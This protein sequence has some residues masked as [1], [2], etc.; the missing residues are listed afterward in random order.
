[1]IPQWKSQG[2]PGRCRPRPNLQETCHT[3]WRSF[4]KSHSHSIC[5]RSDISLMITFPRVANDVLE[6]D[7]EIL[8]ALEETCENG[9]DLVSIHFSTSLSVHGH[10]SIFDD[11]LVLHRRC[12]LACG[13]SSRGTYIKVLEQ[14]NL[15]LW[16][17][18]SHLFPKNQTIEQGLC[19]P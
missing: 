13:G 11:V 8:I 5:A 2:L 3:A 19:V 17:S 7:V 12:Q 9:P 16:H 10:T 4:V 6:N 18:V 1:M 14:I 15:A